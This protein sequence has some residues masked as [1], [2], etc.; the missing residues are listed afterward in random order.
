MKVLVLEPHAHGHH[1][2]YLSWMAR[3]LAERGFEIN[4]V[5]LPETAELPATRAKPGCARGNER[6][7]V[8]FTGVPWSVRLPSGGADNVAGLVARE[9]AYWRLLRAW[10]KAHAE[11]VQPDVVFLPY[12]DYC[13]YAIGL[14]GSPFSG[15]PWVGLAM[16]PSFH[17]QEMG[18]IAPKP[19]LARLKKALFFRMLSHCCPINRQ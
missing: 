14:L 18:V 1:G 6:I 16:R 17:Y 7:S 13:L 15:C 3:G 2:P 5:T 19:S 10:Y 4:V 8:R 9:L 12:L 11:T